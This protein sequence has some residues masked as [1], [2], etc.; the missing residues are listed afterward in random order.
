METG[1]IVGITENGDAAVDYSWYNKIG[2]SLF[3]VI[4]TKKAT[5][6]FV[7][8]VIEKREKII[9]HL[10]CTGWGGTQLEP[11]AYEVEKTRDA[12]DCLISQGFP[13]A[14]IVLRVDP[15]IPTQQGIERVELVL[16]AFADSGIKRLRY[17]FIDNFPRIRSTMHAMGFDL[18]WETIHASQ[19]QRDLFYSLIVHYPQFQYES[20]AE[21]DEHKLGCISPRD[22]E[23]LHLDVPKLK[24]AHIRPGCLCCTLKTELLEST[25]LC[26][27]GCAYC[28]RN[29]KIVFR[30]N[31]TS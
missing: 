5:P 11:N 18:P 1:A 28:Y 14:Q 25:K 24:R 21:K 12:F 10:T 20:C 8:S 27:I 15:V 13:I 16:Q 23:V 4:I 6:Q 19:K 22:F 29:S 2:S 3:S 30:E 7:R 17:S 26:P 9:L 31:D